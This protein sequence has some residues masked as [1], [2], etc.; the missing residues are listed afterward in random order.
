MV[1]N[2]IIE[3]ETDRKVVGSRIMIVTKRTIPVTQEFTD[4][5]VEPDLR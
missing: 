1:E 3:L 4:M 5:V 2:Q